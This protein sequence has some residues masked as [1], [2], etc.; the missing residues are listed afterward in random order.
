[1]IALLGNVCAFKKWLATL[2]S[3][4]DDEKKSSKNL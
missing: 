4:S 2:T 3:Q 1:M